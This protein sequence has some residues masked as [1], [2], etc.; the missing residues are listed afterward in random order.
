MS[1]TK[2][3]IRVLNKSHAQDNFYIFQQTPPVPGDIYAWRNIGQ[4]PAI[5]FPDL[6]DGRVN[7]AIDYATSLSPTGEQL[8]KKAVQDIL[9]IDTGSN[10][11]PINTE[12]D[13]P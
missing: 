4:F 13:K 9:N 3:T 11:L 10:N 12:L 7:W 2:Y 6:K 1:T 8:P 5:S